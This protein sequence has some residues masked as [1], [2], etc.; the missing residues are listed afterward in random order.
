MIPLIELPPCSICRACGTLS[1]ERVCAEKRYAFFFDMLHNVQLEV[2]LALSASKLAGE[3]NV[4]S[5]MRCLAAMSFSL[6]IQRPF[7]I[8]VFTVEMNSFEFHLHWAP[9]PPSRKSFLYVLPFLSRILPE[10]ILAIRRA[11]I[12]LSERMRASGGLVD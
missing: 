9:Y 10:T 8:S 6:V 1:T 7:D 11:A 5:G 2:Y 12:R 3:H 4:T